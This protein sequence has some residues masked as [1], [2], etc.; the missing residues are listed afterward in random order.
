MSQ[1]REKR[2]TEIKT[3]EKTRS[4]QMNSQQETH[5]MSRTRIK[6]T[7]QKK[8]GTIV[9]CAQQFTSGRLLPAA[10]ACR[11]TASTQLCCCHPPKLE[12]VHLT[13]NYCELWHVMSL[14]KHI[15]L[16][17]GTLALCL[18]NVR[19][20]SW[21]DSAENWGTC[22]AGT[23]QSQGGTGGFHPELTCQNQPGPASPCSDSISI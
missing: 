17:T 23:F 11:T 6:K 19:P 14:F 4:Q 13:T 9:S 18:Q 3:D 12:I 22:N 2:Q 10:V 7:D 8:K 15:V 21:W 16:S 20:P 1:R 5:A